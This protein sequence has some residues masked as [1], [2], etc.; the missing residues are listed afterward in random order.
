MANKFG[1][2]AKSAPDDGGLS[3]D[4]DVDV[5]IAAFEAPQ[6]GRRRQ[7]RSLCESL[8]LLF[9]RPPDCERAIARRQEKSI[10]SITLLAN[11]DGGKNIHK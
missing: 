6:D 8:E 9:A 4:G 3:L 7:T 11:L 10:V 2:N 5:L 1:S